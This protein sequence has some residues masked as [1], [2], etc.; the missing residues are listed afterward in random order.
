LNELTFAGVGAHA[1]VDAIC[2][3]VFVVVCPN[4]QRRR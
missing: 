2:L 4:G 1:N 3:F